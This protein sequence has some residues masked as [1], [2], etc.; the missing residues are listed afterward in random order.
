MRVP[1]NKA[2]G[3]RREWLQLSNRSSDD[4]GSGA[5]VLVTTG[6]KGTASSLRS[7]RAPSVSAVGVALSENSKCDCTTPIRYPMPMSVSTN[8]DRHNY[9][10]TRRAHGH[11]SAQG[12]F[13]L[14]QQYVEHGGQL[15]PLGAE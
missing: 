5:T 3:T 10:W 9:P 7:F 1:N 13:H 15:P 2:N 11:S 14:A 12:A 4:R 8:L 6:A